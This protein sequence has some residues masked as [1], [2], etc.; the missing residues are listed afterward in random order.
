MKIALKSEFIFNL[1]K[2]VGL[3]LTF[4]C[5]S[6]HS[7]WLLS[8]KPLHLVRLNHL[9]SS[10]NDDHDHE[11]MMATTSS[12]SLDRLTMGM[13]LVVCCVVNALAEFIIKS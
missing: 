11:M 9:P 2:K 13:L 5:G 8:A 10:S 4:G 3:H 6:S 12:S 1:K 7:Y